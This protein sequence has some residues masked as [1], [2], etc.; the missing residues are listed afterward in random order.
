MLLY[1]LQA[2]CCFYVFIM[3]SP[4]TDSCGNEK[5]FL[6][7]ATVKDFSLRFPP[8]EMTERAVA[9]MGIAVAVT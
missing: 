5:S 2:I 1:L 4:V 3:G 9:M 6:T 8:V 7:I